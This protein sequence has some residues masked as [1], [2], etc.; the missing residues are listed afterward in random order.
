[1]ARGPIAIL[2]MEDAAGA[3]S[4]IAHHLGLGFRRILALSPEPLPLTPEQ[5]LRVTDLGWTSTGRDAHVAVV[6]RVIAAVPPGTWLYYGWNAEYLFF[7]FCETRRV[8]DLLAFHAEE[9]RDAMLTHVIDLYPREMQGFPD[10]FRPEDAMLDLSGYYAVSRRDREGRTLERQFDIHGGLR[11][12]FEEYLP[13]DRLRLDRVALFRA[14]KGL[15]LLPDHRFNVEEY[16]TVSCPWHHNLT[17]AV[18]SFRVAKALARNPRSRRGIE[19]FAWAGSGR[20]DWSSRQ[21][22]DLGMM[23]P[24]QWF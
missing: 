6:N 20:F 21:L 1:M 22:M 13:A 15:T 19:D 10:I 7:P 12:R 4:T 5:R 16:N 14:A 23:E 18:A 8:S 9:R 2:M 11:W 17:A 3:A 24:G